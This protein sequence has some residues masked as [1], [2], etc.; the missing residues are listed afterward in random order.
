[1]PSKFVH[2]VRHKSRHMDAFA[3]SVGKEWVPLIGRTNSPRT[4]TFE[5]SISWWHYSSWPFFFPL[6]NPTRRPSSISGIPLYF[7]TPIA[8]SRG[9]SNAPNHPVGDHRRRRHV[10]LLAIPFEKPV[11]KPLALRPLSFHSFTRKIRLVSLDF[12]SRR[13]P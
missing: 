2:R 9:E 3:Q 7:V 12:S 10:F 8:G 11:V 5:S 1:M 13:A 6:G 4:S